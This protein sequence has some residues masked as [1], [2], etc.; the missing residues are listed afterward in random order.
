MI[1]TI[2][3]PLLFSINKIYVTGQKDHHKHYYSNKMER[4]PNKEISEVGSTNVKET[5]AEIKE[6]IHIT[7]IFATPAP[8]R[9]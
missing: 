1:A 3:Q 2:G 9:V 8:G 5:K 6:S 4:I 7:R